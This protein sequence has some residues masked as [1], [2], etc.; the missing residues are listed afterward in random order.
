M[1][2]AV[3]TSARNIEYSEVPEPGINEDQVLISPLFTGICGTDQHIFNGEFEGRVDYPAILGHEFGGVVLQAGAHVTTCR[4]GDRVVVDPIIP[5]RKCRPCHEGKLSSCVNLKLRGV[6]VPGAMA[7]QVVADENQVFAFPD[8]LSFEWAPMAELYSIACHAAVRGGVKPADTVVILGAGKVG[9]SLVDVFR[10]IGTAD[11]ISVD[12]VPERR[13]VAARLGADYTIDP[14]KENPVDVVETLTEGRGADIVVE[15]VGHYDVT[16]C[17]KPP[18]AAGAEMV[19]NGGRMVILGQGAQETSVLFK[20]LVWKEIEIV[21][22][23]VSR[24]EFSRS[25]S[26]MER[27]LL[28]PDLIISEIFS[29]ED[30]HNVFLNMEQDKASCI[31]AVLRIS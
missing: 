11:L 30:A 23:R 25:V 13:A 7:E 12:P 18:I 1:K 2:A 29:L 3:L 17:M 16:S 24:G 14:G 31:K 20:P 19:R 8:T 10:N 22:S 21:M 15:A 4:E 9:L 28:H 6:D 27:G 5:C 26:M